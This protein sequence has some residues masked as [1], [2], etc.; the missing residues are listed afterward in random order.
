MLS[1]KKILSVIFI[2]L[3][4]LISTCS[5]SARTVEKQMLLAALTFN[6]AR[7]TSWPEQTF[8][9]TASKL[10]LCVLGDN[11]VQLS[12]ANIDNK[13]VNSRVVR[14]I[15]ISR[16]RKLKQCHLLYISELERNKLAPLLFELKEQPILTIGENM[17]FIQAGGMVG[18]EKI[19]GKIKLTINLPRVKQSGLI[20]NSRL[21]KLANIVD[22]STTTH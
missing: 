11:L 4:F 19:N 12:L 10:N 5:L 15:N 2:L 21:L 3:I 20:I 9:D 18:L 16:L 17:A 1:T 7:F 8:N 14:I 6:V 13:T 22:S